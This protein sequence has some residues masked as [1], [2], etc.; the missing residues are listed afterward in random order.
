[1]YDFLLVINSI[2]GPI[3]HRYWDTATYW[4]K[5]VNVA[6]PLAFSALV[7]GDLLRTYGKALWFL[8]LESSRQPTV[9][10]WWF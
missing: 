2:L 3:L 5:I 8:K 6:H 10:I 4:P 9:K 7:Q 1:V